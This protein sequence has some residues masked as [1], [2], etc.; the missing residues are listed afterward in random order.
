MNRILNF[1]SE[2]VLKSGV[3]YGSKRDA[4]REQLKAPAISHPD[5][6]MKHCAY[7]H[8]VASLLTLSGVTSHRYSLIVTRYATVVVA[9]LSTVHCPANY[10]ILI[11]NL[12]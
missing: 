6:R 8:S 2:T 4:Q 10:N 3:Q 5:M 11:Y 1:P 7:G 9:V 12:R